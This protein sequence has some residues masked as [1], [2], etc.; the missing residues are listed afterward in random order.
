MLISLK[1]RKRGSA[2]STPEKGGKRHEVEYVFLNSFSNDRVRILFAETLNVRVDVVQTISLELDA[3]KIGILLK[4]RKRSVA[5][6][7]LPPSAT[8]S[9]LIRSFLA[10][11]YR[12]LC[13]LD[14]VRT[15]KYF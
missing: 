12:F 9:F 4:S 8:Q 1:D 14:W 3:K 6:L 15:L 2:V 11:I 7:A 5:N 10:K 13:R